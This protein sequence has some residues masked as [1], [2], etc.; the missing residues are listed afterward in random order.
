VLSLL[1]QIGTFTDAITGGRGYLV[2]ASLTVARCFPLSVSLARLAFGAAD[3]FEPAAAELRC[4]G[5]A[6]RI[7]SRR[8]DRTAQMPC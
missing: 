7:N 2:L 4:A 6:W 1:Q 5:G 8:A 3:A